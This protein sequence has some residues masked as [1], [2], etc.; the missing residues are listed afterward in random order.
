MSEAAG[1]VYEPIGVVRSGHGVAVVELLRREGPVL[2]PDG[3]G[4]LDGTPLLDVKPYTSR[5]DCIQTDRDG[6]QEEVDERTARHRGR[7]LFRAR[8]TR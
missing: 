1:I 2:Y 6:R 7:R 3:A 8:G 4:V 5:F